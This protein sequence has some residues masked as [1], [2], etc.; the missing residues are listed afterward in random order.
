MQCCPC[1]CLQHIKDHFSN[2]INK[3]AAG[4]YD[5]WMQ[6]PLA[7]VAGIVLADQFTR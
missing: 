1:A 5:D 3:L 4:S 7:A 6:Q 2:D